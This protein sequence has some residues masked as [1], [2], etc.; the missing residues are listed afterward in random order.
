M[1][2][3]GSALMFAQLVALPFHRGDRLDDNNPDACLWYS[4]FFEFTLIGELPHTASSDVAC[5]SRPPITPPTPRFDATCSAPFY[6]TCPC[7]AVVVVW[8]LPVLSCVARVLA[9]GE[10]WFL[11]LSLDL[12]ATIRNPFTSHKRNRR[13]YM[14]V[15]N[16]SALAASIALAASRH[17]GRSAFRF[18]FV[19]QYIRPG[20]IEGINVT[21]WALFYI[22]LLCIYAFSVVVAVFAVLRLGRG[23][24]E[25]LRVRALVLKRERDCVV[26]FLVYWF[27][28]ILFYVVTMMSNGGGGE[29]ANDNEPAIGFTTLFLCGRSVV[30]LVVRDTRRVLAFGVYR[31]HAR[32]HMA[33]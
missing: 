30:S 27:V 16:V 22:P 24:R 9:A 19:S 23:L 18:C 7:N 25:T 12:F 26:A 13:M 20:I 6:C 3:T 15:F 2:G 10:L 33:A 4:F 11:G 17:Y 28:T 29:I 1:E 21:L 31:W 5:A 8:P 14:V 32:R